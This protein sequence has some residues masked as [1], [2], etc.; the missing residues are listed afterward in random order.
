MKWVFGYGSIIW[1]P[2][3]PYVAARPALIRG[4]RRR[5]WQG[6]PDHRGTAEN[7]GR[8]VTL[9]ADPLALCHGVA[10][11]TGDDDTPEIVESL[12][13]RESGGYVRITVD[14][15]FA[16]MTR[17]QAMTYIA[18]P[19]N[20]NFLGPAAPEDI[21]RQIAASAGASGHNTEYVLKLAEALRDLEIL[22]DEVHLLESRLRAYVDG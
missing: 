4:W 13:V 5:F 19:D 21:V 14:V 8:V 12:D 11:D 9:V 17:A 1:R 16:D 7:P 10:F 2:A 15:E 18:P 20:S 22:D 6:S 3:F